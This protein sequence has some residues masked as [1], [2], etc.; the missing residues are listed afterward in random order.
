MKSPSWFALVLLSFS[1]CG[2][3]REYRLNPAHSV[4][5]ALPMQKTVHTIRAGGSEPVVSPLNCMGNGVAEVIVS[6]NF[7]QRL[8]SILTLGIYNPV[9]IKW[10]CAKDLYST[11]KP[12]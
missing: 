2:C 11:A 10:R 6:R 9:T 12:F 4:P 7:N 1:T 5:T 3:T 8:G